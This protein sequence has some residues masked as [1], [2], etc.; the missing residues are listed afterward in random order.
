MTPPGHEKARPERGSAGAERFPS[1]RGHGRGDGADDRVLVVSR[2]EALAGCLD[3][4]QL[5]QIVR[6]AVR[7]SGHGGADNVEGEGEAFDPQHD[8]QHVCVM[9][10]L[11]P[12]QEPHQSV[13][14]AWRVDPDRSAPVVADADRARHEAVVADP[15]TASRSSR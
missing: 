12:A 14:A 9:R 4:K 15:P 6:Q 3:L 5:L 13:V 2:I 10:V 1:H 8:A 11:A 7:H